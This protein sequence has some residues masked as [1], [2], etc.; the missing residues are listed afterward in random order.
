MTE[1]RKLIQTLTNKTISWDM[2]NYP[3]IILKNCIVSW[4]MN[5]IWTIIWWK[6]SWDMNIV[7]YW[8]EI[9]ITW[10]MN[11]IKNH[12]DI[13]EE[14]KV[15][16]D[17]SNLPEEIRE[18]LEIKDE[19]ESLQKETMEKTLN[20]KKRTNDYYKKYGKWFEKTQAYLTD[21]YKKN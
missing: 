9:Q 11:T 12:F 8:S 3:N 6:I 10:D 15:W 21:F 5:R 16:P 19:A 2:W 20:L 18:A 17:R 1:S 4:D 13:E 14:K 7:T